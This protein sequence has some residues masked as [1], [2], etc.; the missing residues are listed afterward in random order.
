MTPLHEFVVQTADG[1]SDNL[2]VGYVVATDPPAGT[3]TKPNS[4][5]K[6]FVVKGPYPVHVPNV[7]A[8]QRADAENQL[9]AQGFQV[10]VKVKDDQGQ[11][12]DKVLDQDPPGGQGVPSAQGVTVTLTVASGP[13]GTAMLGVVGAPCQQA[14]AT[15]QAAGITVDVGGDPISQQVGKVHDQSPN[16]GENVA[17][18]AHAHITCAV[19]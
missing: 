13:P 8:M 4:V 18:G 17:P 9:K 10:A 2:P 19:F 3:P 16:P 14:V 11:P 15:L 6:V 12:K 1:F 7:L 5:L